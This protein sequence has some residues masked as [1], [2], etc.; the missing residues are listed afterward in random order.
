MTKREVCLDG[1]APWGFRM[2]GGADSGH[3]LRIS[4]VNPGSKAAQQGVREGDVISA[5]NGTPTRLLSNG[6][7]HALLRSAGPTLT[8][9]LNQDSTG[10]PKRRSRDGVKRTDSGSGSQDTKSQNETVI[11]AQVKTVTTETTACT[12]SS[13]PN[14]QGKKFKQ[15]KQESTEDEIL[16]SKQSDSIIGE[17]PVLEEKDL[18][19]SNENHPNQKMSSSRARRLRKARLK[20]KI[21][22]NSSENSPYDENSFENSSQDPLNNNG[23]KESSTSSVAVTENEAET[24]DQPRTIELKIFTSENNNNNKKINNTSCND[25]NNNNQPPQLQNEYQVTE[26]EFEKVSVHYDD[27]KDKQKNI[28][29]KSE[30]ETNKLNSNNNNGSS[31]NRR[32]NKQNNDTS[33]TKNVLNNSE[34]R[35]QNKI[36]VSEGVSSVTTSKK[37]G[38]PTSSDVKSQF[39]RVKNIS[40][41]NTIIISE[42]ANNE[43]VSIKEEKSISDVKSQNYSEKNIRP[44]NKFS[45]SK[46]TNK[47]F[48]IEEKTTSLGTKSQIKRESNTTPEIITICKKETVK[49]VDNISLVSKIHVVEGKDCNKTDKI[50]NKG[51]KEN[52]SRGT[53]QEKCDSDTHEE[54]R[55]ITEILQP[56]PDAGNKKIESDRCSSEEYEI[57]NIEVI[58]N[59]PTPT[60]GIENTFFSPDWESVEELETSSGPVSSDED[61]HQEYLV[62]LP[63]NDLRAEVISPLL[64]EDGIDE[65]GLTVQDIRNPLIPPD[66]EERLRNFLQTLDLTKPEEYDDSSSCKSSEEAAVVVEPESSELYANKQEIVIYKH[67][68][69]RCVAEPCYIPSPH[70]HYLDVI[71]EEN[72]DLS[73]G[74]RKSEGGKPWEDSETIRKNNEFDTIPDDWIDSDNDG[75]HFTDDGGI[76]SWSEGTTLDEVDGV[77]IV[78]LDSDNSDDTVIRDTEFD[79]QHPKLVVVQTKEI[80]KVLSIETSD[81]K[82]LEPNKIETGK[83]EINYFKKINN[84]KVDKFYSDSNLMKEFVSEES[85][86]KDKST[87]ISN[88]DKSTSL[89]NDTKYADNA[90]SFIKENVIDEINDLN[91]LDLI[92]SS[93]AFPKTE[94]DEGIELSSF[95]SNTDTKSSDKL[96][97]CNILKEFEKQQIFQLTDEASLS[98]FS[99][100]KCMI[101]P[102][103]KLDVSVTPV[104]SRQNSSSSGTPTTQS[105]TRCTTSQSPL[106]SERDDKTDSSQLFSLDINYKTPE[107]LKEL[108]AKRVISLPN[109]I[110][111]LEEVG[112]IR[113]RT[114]NFDYITETLNYKERSISPRNASRRSSTLPESPVET[115]PTSHPLSLLSSSLPN[116]IFSPRSSSVLMYTPPSSNINSP[117]YSLPYD[118]DE[119]WTSVQTSDENVRVCLSPSQSKSRTVPANPKEA[120][121]LLDL[122]KKF[123]QRRGYHEDN[124]RYPN[125]NLPSPDLIQL[126]YYNEMRKPQ[127][128]TP[129]LLTE[130]A[131]LLALKEYRK[132]RFTENQPKQE[133]VEKL[134]DVF[135][136]NKKTN[137]PS[138]NENEIERSVKADKKLFNN[139]YKTD[140][141]K[142]LSNSSSCLNEKQIKRGG[143]VFN[144]SDFTCKIPA[145]SKIF[146]DLKGGELATESSECGEPGCVLEQSDGSRLLALIQSQIHPAAK[147]HRPIATTALCNPLSDRSGEE[148]GK[149]YTGSADFVSGWLTMSRNTVQSDSSKRVFDADQYRISKQGDIAVMLSPD[150]K[151]PERP[152]SLPPSVTSGGEIFRQKMYEEYMDK[153]AERYERRQQKV[154]KISD[155][156][157]SMFVSKDELGDLTIPSEIPK[158]EEEFM[159]KVKERMTKLGIPLEDNDDDNNKPEKVESELPKHLQE[160]VQLTSESPKN[161]VWSPVQTPE[162]QRKVFDFNS[163][164]QERE[165]EE[166]EKKNKEDDT[167]TPPIWSP[168]SA[169][170]P[171]SEKKTFRPIKFESPPPVRK[172]YQPQIEEPPK[173]PTSLPITP[174]DWSQKEKSEKTIVSES[175]ET[176]RRLTSSQSAESSLAASTETTLPRAPNPTITLLQKARE[177]QLPRGA[178]YLEDEKSSDIPEEKPLVEP[179]E[180]IYSVRREYSS[181]TE[182]KKPKKIV[183]LGPRKFEGI[184]PT[185]R[186][187]IP[188]VLR[189]EVKDAN[190]Q[191]WYK[192]MYDSLH[193]ADK[194]R[195][196]VTVRYKTNRRGYPYSS[197]GGYLSEPDRLGT[198]YDSDAASTK[199]ATLDRRRIRNKEN[200]FTTSTMP[201]SKYVAN[202]VK[203][204]VDVYKNQPGRIEDYEPG[205]SSISEKEA[206]QQFE[207][208]Q[209][210]S[211]PPPTTPN[212][213]KPFMTYALKESGYESDSTLVFKRRDENLQNQLAMSP[214]E[215]K[216]AYKTI[217][218]GG[219]VPLHGLRKP[220]PER[221][222]EPIRGGAIPVPERDFHSKQQRPE[223]P[224]RYVESEVTIHYRSPVR[225]EAK[226]AWPEEELARRQAE[227]MRRIYQEERRRKYL[228]E[229]QDMYSRRHTDNFIPSQKSPIPLNRYDDFLDDVSPTKPRDHTPEPKLVARALY[230]FVGQSSRELTFRRGD[231]IFVRRQIDKNWY[232]GEHNAMIGLFPINYVEI[233]PYDGIRTTPKR[234]SEGQARA[235]FNFQA[236]T[237]LE[238]SLVKGEL[239]VLTRRVDDNWFEGKIGNRKGIFPV[240]Y[241]EVLVEPG[242]RTV[243]PVRPTTPASN[244]PVAS[245]AAHSLMLNGAKNSLSHHHYTPP[246][247][248]SYTSLSRPMKTTK[249]DL[250]PVNQTLHIDTQSEPVPYRALYNYKP[251]NDDELE[252]NEG[253]TVYVME[254][255]DDGWYVGSSQRTGCFGTFPGNYVQRLSRSH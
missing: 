193:R 228:Q 229:L 217:Q 35:Q 210:S 199:Y 107:S 196:F 89:M 240:S 235:K 149:K 136:S 93:T 154:I 58:V 195:E 123:I 13:Q 105:T 125:Q 119:H 97:K 250:A 20:N 124:R 2:N 253:D 67:C 148:T 94:R 79:E 40:P 5:I 172:N 42:V 157:T 191:K 237:Q 84:L 22:E 63:P 76:K 182:D 213:G 163:A 215:Q 171:P 252:L 54:V 208:S 17:S 189:S 68:K 106:L 48:K 41:E 9:G 118:N 121:G 150:A 160:F 214:A 243:S 174:S 232:E 138:I 239:V 49:V 16:D 46:S 233:I 114:D 10:S 99:D 158:L 104:F 57:T 130:A 71:T 34:S 241:V 132:T 201:R 25:N 226:E 32:R 80:N 209:K 230:N 224:H 95:E 15:R 135:I 186:E 205:H 212:T 247:P 78:Y 183:E 91:F 134:N 50:I 103:E 246:P 65:Y 111:I 200:D 43:S 248:V 11:H 244:K 29:E 88:K 181:E 30:S 203:H 131:N 242:D 116:D 27:S 86:I 12:S 179:N 192:R 53:L 64:L 206:K 18:Q 197:V 113:F 169:P 52:L 51:S 166:E 83:S 162:A 19:S 156:P 140:V 73:D 159:V 185:T 31:K 109:G 234:P 59:P 56:T 238:L 173:P 66:E 126:E 168:R 207:Q 77:E 101:I 236:Q 33:F 96:S 176:H 45:I 164:Q 14:K 219:E 249:S 62:H 127:D 161:G 141:N 194:D 112:I 227:A 82:D 61:I 60:L 137:N 139:E 24:A 26:R 170:S 202:S 92:K 255:C 204:A 143:R 8:L 98:Y 128:Y 120:A 69:S 225:S 147:A 245:P 4:R 167:S 144:E 47:E 180:I 85:N 108:S 72:S 7:S 37:E 153:V 81:T 187:G 198:D 221:P 222:K 75:E 100:E 122:H 151:R 6:E 142:E 155:R 3:P 115:R 178:H 74:D 28:L 1:G 216:M 102:Q 211:R 38:K 87:E 220:A 251:Q 110:K 218:K 188:I 223:S 145:K 254:K 117:P 175:I 70:R 152:K 231:V 55:T 129:E 21:K 90:Q 23:C 39:K 190:Q 44:E 177:G 184:G 146:S 133:K 165:K 36:N